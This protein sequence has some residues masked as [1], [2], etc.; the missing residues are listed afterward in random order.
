MEGST[1]TKERSGEM[2]EKCFKRTSALGMTSLHKELPW[3]LDGHLR[4]G[5]VWGW[6]KEA[7]KLIL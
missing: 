2:E 5:D 4:A 7:G 6:M 1:R 3:S